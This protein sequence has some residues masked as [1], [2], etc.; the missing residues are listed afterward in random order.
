VEETYRGG[1]R[2]GPCRTWYESGQLK[3]EWTYRDD[4]KREGPCR[5]WY[6]SGQLKAEWIFRNGKKDA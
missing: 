1:K 3:A 4:G 6:E 2:E 5:T